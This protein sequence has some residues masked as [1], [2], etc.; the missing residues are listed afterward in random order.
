MG[1]ARRTCRSRPS[2]RRRQA[3][4]E[5]SAARAST[6]R[7]GSPAARER[8][9]APRAWPSPRPGRLRRPMPGRRRRRRSVLVAGGRRGRGTGA[10]PAGTFGSPVGAAARSAAGGGVEPRGR[11]ASGAGVGRGV[12]A[13][14]GRRRSG[15]R[16]GRR[17]RE[18][19]GGSSPTIALG[20]MLRSWF[21]LPAPSSLS[22]RMCHGAPET[23]PRRRARRRSAL[24]QYADW[25]RW[26]PHASRT[27][28]AGR[29]ELHEE[30]GRAVAVRR[31]G[32]DRA[33]DRR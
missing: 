21:L 13:R 8:D 23:S 1:G 9:Q 24:S 30:V 25:A 32:V 2:A 28:D 10:A 15:G 33:L 26:P 4:A 7:C 6:R 27:A 18:G 16:A 22:V 31:A 11:P 12:G 14:G 5:R 17:R 29:L 20:W 19:S 3:S